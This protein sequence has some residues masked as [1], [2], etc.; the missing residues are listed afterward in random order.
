MA[1]VL[2]SALKAAVP[3]LRSALFSILLGFLWLGAF[4]LVAMIP[5]F[6]HD[7]K[8]DGFI[9]DVIHLWGWLSLSM[10]FTAAVSLDVMIDRVISNFH[11][12]EHDRFDLSTSLGMIRLLSLITLL[13][14]TAC[15]GIAVSYHGNDTEWQKQIESLVLWHLA[16]GWITK[17]AWLY[18]S[19]SI[20][21]AIYSEAS[22]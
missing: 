12:K 4:I 3:I 2:S 9:H 20:P 10:G 14:L 8:S 15:L 1:L 6:A 18:Q 13:I 19:P 21:K 17:S 22:K 7:L 16:I 11:N 5:E